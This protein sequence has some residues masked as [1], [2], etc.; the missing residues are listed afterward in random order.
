MRS[1]R[2]SSL[3]GRVTGNPFRLVA[4][5]K[6]SFIGSFVNG[7]GFVVPEAKARQLIAAGPQNDTVLLPYLTGE[8]LNASPC[9]AATRWII[10]F[11]DWPIERAQQD[12]D[13]FTIVDE[14]VRPEREKVNRKAHRERWWQYGDKR[15]EL[16]A[17]ID[18][19]D[20]VLVI[21]ATSK[22]VQPSFVP[23]GQV[24]SHALA[25][26]AYDDDF[27]FG[28][29]SSGFHWWWAVTYAS[30]MRSDLRYTPSDVFETFPQP[31]YT[32]AVEAA[33]RTLDSHR[34]ALMLRNDEGLTKTYN[35]V[36]N[37]EDSSPGITDLRELH[38]ALDHAVRDAYGWSDLD[39]DHDFHDTPQGRRFTL[40]P[41]A[42][43]EVLNRLLELNHR[44]MPRRSRSGSTARR[45]RRSRRRR[46]PTRRR[47]CC[48]SSCGRH[49]AVPA[50]RSS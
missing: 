26:F 11:F 40:G 36:H 20:R 42:R 17:A 50:A 27:H 9:Q 47:R 45:R 39:L 32:A 14:K 29:L 34:S 6:R 35:R 46:S 8:D 28:V 21:A 41:A 37:P 38:V 49:P 24:L 48:S 22:L 4:E 23:V 2:H 30:T 7:I 18:G 10:N 33:G 3:A 16:Y 13:C 19:R 5:G 12:P 1:R 43:T 31:P 44:G 15:P 25:V